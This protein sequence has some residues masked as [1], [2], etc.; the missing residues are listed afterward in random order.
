M[1]EREYALSAKRDFLRSKI[2]DAVNNVSLGETRLWACNV[3][4][5]QYTDH[6]FT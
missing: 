2:I 6:S 4:F 3:Y 1:L 5:R